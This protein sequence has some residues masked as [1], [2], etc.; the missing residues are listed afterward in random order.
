MSVH[1]MASCRMPVTRKLSLPL[2]RHRQMAST[3]LVSVAM[4]VY[5]SERYVA[6]AIESVLN[7]SFGD[8]ELLII[9]DGST[10]ETPH[11]LKRY[12]QADDRVRVVWQEHRGI[13]YT[14]NRAWESAQGTYLAWA[15]SDDLCLPQRLEKQVAFLE[16]HKDIAVC[17]GAIETFGNSGI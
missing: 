5:N 9:D 12:E 8:F 15:D 13:P 6:E 2:S 7:Q 16:R 3:P 10:D 4:P 11:I 17:G 14:R 1:M